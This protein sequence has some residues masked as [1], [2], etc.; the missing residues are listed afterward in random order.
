MAQLLFYGPGSGPANSPAWLSFQNQF[1]TETALQA[2]VAESVVNDLLI[3]QIGDQRRLN[4]NGLTKAYAQRQVKRRVKAYTAIVAFRY[5]I[6]FVGRQI[7][8][9]PRFAVS[10][11]VTR[12]TATDIGIYALFRTSQ[13]K[14]GVRLLSRFIPYLGWGLAA[15]DI[16]TIIF[17][18]ELWGVQIYEKA[19]EHGQF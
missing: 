19:D 1:R 7:L 4:F 15:W 14:V 10:R 17:R 3:L 13:K 8:N 2:G 6:P 12:V 5:G 16:Y 18:G 11:G 9:H